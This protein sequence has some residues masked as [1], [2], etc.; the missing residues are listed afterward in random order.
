MPSSSAQVAVRRRALPGV[1]SRHFSSAGLRRAR[2]SSSEVPPHTPEVTRGPSPRPGTRPA[3]AG[4]AYPFS[5]TDLGKRGPDRADREEEVCIGV[6]AGGILTPVGA[7]GHRAG[8]LADC[9]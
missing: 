5:L 3:P 9:V 7:Y 2:R 8:V 4:R 1:T 6:T